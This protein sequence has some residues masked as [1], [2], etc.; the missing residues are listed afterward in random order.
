MTRAVDKQGLYGSQET[1]QKA[2]VRP[3]RTSRHASVVVVV[4]KQRPCPCASFPLP[5]SSARAAF[6]LAVP[7]GSKPGKASSPSSASASSRRLRDRPG[8]CQRSDMTAASTTTL[9]T[10]RRIEYTRTR[11][12]GRSV[13]IIVGLLPIHLLFI[14]I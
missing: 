11:P 9:R 2:S 4:A 8:A 6:A 12:L 5:A 13:R 1:K 10:G 3:S 14:L 7:Q